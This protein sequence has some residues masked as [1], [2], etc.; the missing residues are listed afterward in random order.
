MKRIMGKYGVDELLDT[1]I[2]AEIANLLFTQTSAIQDFIGVL[3]KEGRR[4]ANL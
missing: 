2:L 1:S 3:R 4:R